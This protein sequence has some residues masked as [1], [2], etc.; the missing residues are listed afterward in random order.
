[1][2]SRRWARDE[3]TQRTCRLPPSAAELG[4]QIAPDGGGLL[5]P[6]GDRLA[7]ALV[8]HDDG[9]VGEALA[10][11]LPQRRVGRARAAAPPATGRAAGRRGCAATAAAPPAR[12]PAPRPPRTA[13]PAPSARSRSTSCSYTR[14][15]PAA[16]PSPLGERVGLRGPFSNAAESPPLPARPNDLRPRHA[17]RCVS[18][19]HRAR[20]KSWPRVLSPRGEGTVGGRCWRA[21]CRHWPSLSSRAGTCTWSAL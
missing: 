10:L 21:E 1:M 19:R 14:S 5:G 3:V 11:L 12:P 4:F 7:Q 18:R 16:S 2:R 17:S 13:A 20:P 6:A 9:D 8:D 15:P